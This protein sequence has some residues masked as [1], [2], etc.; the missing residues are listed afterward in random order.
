MVECQCIGV[1]VRNEFVMSTS[2]H[3]VTK[4][5]TMW[6]LFFQAIDYNAWKPVRHIDLGLRDA[7]GL[8]VS[9]NWLVVITGYRKIVVHVYSLPYGKKHHSQTFAASSRWDPYYIYTQKGWRRY[10]P[11]ISQLAPRADSTGLIYVPCSTYVA[12][13]EISETG[14]LTLVWNVTAG[15]ELWQNAGISLAVAPETDQL[16]VASYSRPKITITVVLVNTAN[17]SI[18]RTLRTLRLPWFV[19]ARPLTAVAALDTGQ[20]FVSCL[21]WEG[22]DF[23]TVLYMYRSVSEP[24]ELLAGIPLTSPGNCLGHLNHFLVLDMSDSSIIRV[25]SDNGTLL[26][27]VDV[28]NGRDGV[29]LPHAVDVAIWEDCG[30]VLGYEEGSLVLLCPI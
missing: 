26:H 19:S 6:F 25:V 20:I 13:L 27:T 12:V 11:Y 14:N 22:S 16:Y 28:L 17:N 4:Y 24:P 23:L 9:K 7:D 29:W 21:Y 5:I 3:Y 18:A 2:L 30:W 10:T 1:Q 15:G 8:C